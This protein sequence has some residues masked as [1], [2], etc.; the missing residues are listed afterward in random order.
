MPADG[1]KGMQVR[2][3]LQVKPFWEGIALQQQLE[4]LSLD[5]RL[6]R[7]QAAGDR[8]LSVELLQLAHPPLHTRH[9]WFSVT[10]KLPGRL[11]LPYS[12]SCMLVHC[13]R[14]LS[15]CNNIS[16]LTK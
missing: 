13:C 15:E 12:L 14:F 16:L 8:R 5:V 6:L 7:T 3:V 10:K 4:L 2:H 1:D 11:Q 9:D